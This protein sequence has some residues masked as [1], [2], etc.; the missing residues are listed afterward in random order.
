LRS[1]A[2]RT[3]LESS[4]YESRVALYVVP[5]NEVL[6]IAQHTLALLS[7]RNASRPA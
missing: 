2:P 5:T 6:M 1:A 3:P 4:S 7:A